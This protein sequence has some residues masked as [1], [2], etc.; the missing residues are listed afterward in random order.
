MG[1][2][3]MTDF[4]DWSSNV[5][6]PARPVDLVLLLVRLSDLEAVHPEL[7]LLKHS[8]D[9][10]DSPINQFLNDLEQYDTMAT[11]PLVVLLCPGPPPTA[12]R[13]DAMERKVQ[14]KIE[15][16]Q[17]VTV[18]SSERLLSLFEQQY[19]T[20]FYDVVADKRQHSPYT[21]AMLNVMSLSL[22]RQICRLY[23]TAGSR[24]KVI[25]LDCDNTLWGGAVAEV[26]PSGIDLGTRF[27]ALQRFVIAQQQRGMLLALC[28]KNILEDVTEAFTQRR[29]DMVLDLDKHVVATK[30][31]WKPKS[32][33]IAQLAKEL[34]LGLDSF[35][36]I[37]DNPLECNEVATAL[38]SVT[39][40]PLGADFSESVLDH[41]W[42]FDDGLDIRSSGSATSTKEDNDRTQLYQQNLQREQLREFSSTHKAFL[43]ALGVKI[44]FEELDRDQELQQRSSSFTRALQLHHR[45]NQF[46]TATTFA[47][48][49]EEEELL[50]YI[51]APEHTVICAHVTDRFGHYG[52]VNVALCRHARDHNVLLVDSFLLSCRALNRGVEHAMMRKL[53]EVAVR[54]GATQLEFAWEP[55]ERNQPA[56]AFFSS[57]SDVAFEIKDHTKA[58]GKEKQQ[59]SISKAGTWVTAVDKGS[60][61]SFLKTE[62]NRQHSIKTDGLISWLLHLPSGRWL[63]DRTLS[64]VRWM[65]SSFAWS[66]RLATLLK[67]FVVQRL[68]NANSAG[69]LRVSLRDRGSLERFITPALLDIRKVNNI[70]VTESDD[71]NS[72]D[73]FR[74]K[75]RHQTKMALVNHLHGE[76]PGVIWSANRPHT[77]GQTPVGDGLTV[78]EPTIRLQLVCKSPQCSAT[79]Q[80]E[81]R[82]AFQRCRNCCYRIQRLLTRSLHHANANARQSAVN[83]LLADF[84]LDA[85]TEEKQSSGLDEQWCVA[86]QNKRRRGERFKQKISADK[87]DTSSR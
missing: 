6:N 36:F 81:S 56:H 24:K 40:I 13:F 64:A 37:D 12:T 61:V 26:G 85:S 34:S 2:G 30:V 15:A 63:R 35:I 21:Q 49:L 84:A 48:R 58:T 25:V 78:P 29:K 44:V 83:A 38:P 1:Y 42:V 14:S 55:T 66:Q 11:A 33:N 43:S 5:L 71:S 82:C 27:L 73:K 10:L 79:I 7:Q 18:Q 16:M 59:V 77:D 69:F 65:L 75:A 20:A 4:E 87:I 47:K 3:S 50:K 86:H 52:L 80:R 53:S 28:S 8:D 57:L 76:A 23:R 22:S 41:E 62:D 72:D 70:V 39:V 74:R 67:P 45:T 60:Q 54:I 9:V 46:N 32:E 19:R 31:N 68:N 17:N 51:A